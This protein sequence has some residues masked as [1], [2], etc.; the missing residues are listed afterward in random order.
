[1][2]LK[3]QFSQVKEKKKKKNKHVARL[4]FCLD[5]KKKIEN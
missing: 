2:K 1:M 4:K 5:F 3:I